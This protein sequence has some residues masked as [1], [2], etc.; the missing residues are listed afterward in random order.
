MKSKI[1]KEYGDNSQ[2]VQKMQ[3]QLKNVQIE[4][5]KKATQIE[6]MEFLGTAGPK[7]AVKVTVKGDKTLSFIEV[8]DNNLISPENKEQ[9]FDY[10]VTAANK[11]FNQV[12]DITD[13]EIDRITKDLPIKG[14]K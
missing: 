14:L 13:Q 3:E 1:M 2:K 4:M 12:E 10:I 6:S 9:L 8:V 5:Q 11:A 7:D